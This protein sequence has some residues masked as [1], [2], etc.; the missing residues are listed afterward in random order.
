MQTSQVKL[1]QKIMCFGLKQ[2]DAINNKYYCNFTS[3]MFN[4]N[5]PHLQI[6]FK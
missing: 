6:Q 5:S 3:K 2:N 4:I 1:S